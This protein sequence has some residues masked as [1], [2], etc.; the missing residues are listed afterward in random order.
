MN[1]DKDNFF[2]N[3]FLLIV[4][5]IIIGIFGF[6]FLIYFFKILGFEGMGFYNLVMLIYNLFICFMVVGVVVFIFKIVV[7]YI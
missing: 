1:K 2:K 7:I 6:I 5:N 3:I 4:L